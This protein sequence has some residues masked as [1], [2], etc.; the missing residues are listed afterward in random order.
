MLILE[1]HRHETIHD[2]CDFVCVYCLAFLFFNY[3][4]MKFQFP[5]CCTKALS[6]RVIL[7][8]TFVPIAS[9]TKLRLWLDSN[10]FVEGK[11]PTGRATAQ[12]LSELHGKLYVFGGT[13]GSE[14]LND[15]HVYH[16][17]SR[18]WV[19]VT[20]HLQGSVPSPRYGHAFISA[21]NKLYLFGG[22]SSAGK[23]IVFVSFFTTLP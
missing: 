23:L 9:A 20:S 7:I 4:D 13:K 18:T 15:M 19:D 2:S 17:E 8:L 1:R 14:Y 21:L 22:R 3:T 5:L 12:F 10:Q 11:P 16:P 6:L